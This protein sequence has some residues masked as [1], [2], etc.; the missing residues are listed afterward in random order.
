[1]VHGTCL[2]KQRIEK[3]WPV[4]GARLFRRL[5]YVAFLRCHRAR[6][7]EIAFA[8]TSGNGKADDGKDNRQ[9]DR[10]G[11]LVCMGFLLERRWWTSS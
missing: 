4:D 7:I 6:R 1:M 8:S 5:R 10:C 11:K 9:A 2:S 3:E